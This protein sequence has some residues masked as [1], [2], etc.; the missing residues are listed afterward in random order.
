MIPIFFFF[1]NLVSSPQLQDFA[2]VPVFISF[3]SFLSRPFILPGPCLAVFLISN[4]IYLHSPSASW[5]SQ[6]RSLN[7]LENTILY[8]S[9]ILW[10]LGSWQYLPFHFDSELM[11]SAVSVWFSS[12]FC[13]YLILDSFKPAFLALLFQRAIVNS[14]E[15]IW[16]IGVVLKSKQEFISIVRT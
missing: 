15:N 14:V 6:F 13:T 3:Y 8:R 16:I 9:D 5:R 7:C 4:L 12:S 11:L 1:F 10:A 2:F